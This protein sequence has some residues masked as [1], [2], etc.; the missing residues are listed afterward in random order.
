MYRINPSYD[1]FFPSTIP[2]RIS[3]GIIKY[4]WGAYVESLE[5]G[6]IVLTY[7]GGAGCR[8]GIYGI[9]VVRNVNVTS[10]EM[11]VTARL[12]HYSCDDRVPLVPVQEHRDLFQKIRTRPRGAEVVVPDSHSS[13]VYEALA[14]NEELLAEARKWNIDLPGESRLRAISLRQ[15]PLVNLDNDLS[16][17]IQDKGLIP[18]FWIRPRQAS[19]IVRAPRWLSHISR[20]FNA[21]KSGDSSRLDYLSDR[22]VQQIRRTAPR[23]QSVFS[24]ILSVPLNET[25]RA[26][27]EVDRVR[28]LTEAISNKIRIPY[29][30]IFKLQ[31]NISRRLYKHL[32]Y[33]TECF[34]KNYKKQLEVD[35]P[36]QLINSFN[37]GQKILLIDDVYTD[38]VTTA[39]IIDTL[40]QKF[41]NHEV[42]VT[43]ATLGMMTKQN[44]MNRD[45]IES[46]R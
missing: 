7:F 20:I 13:A 2:E 39:V 43:I 3:R 10:N 1:G 27:G 28:R 9:A 35:T 8:K 44:N 46:W 42:N 45:L 23:A 24:F 25:K 19:W 38:G 16:T 17:G 11:N 30:D 21:F 32:G 36:R 29:L 4:N 31:G 15:I 26:S 5:R 41:P 40:K 34:R 18:V 22:M 37:S 12:L 14:S 6:D 33:S